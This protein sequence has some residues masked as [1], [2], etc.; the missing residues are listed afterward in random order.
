MIKIRA[1]THYFN[2]FTNKEKQSLLSQFVDQYRDVTQSIIDHLW[3]NEISFNDKIFDV[4]KDLLD[5]PSFISTINL[6]LSSNLY[7]RAIKCA[8]T[9]A[10]SIIKG[11]VEKRKKRLY[12]LEQL[13]QEGKDTA[14]LQEKMDKHP[15]NK[16]KVPDNFKCELN[17]ICCDFLEGENSFDGFIQLKSIGKKYGKIRIPIKFHRQ[18]N[19]WKNKGI[20][21]P[22]FLISK[23]YINMRWEIDFPE[24]RK[25]GLIVGADSGL[26]TCL[27]LSDGQ[28]TKKCPHGH[29]LRSI[30]ETL[31]RRKQGG[32]GFQR[33]QDHRENYVNWSINQLDLDGIKQINLEEIYD[34]NRGKNTSKL[35]KRWKNTLI[36]DKVQKIGEE[37]G[38]QIKLQSSPYRSQRC[39]SCGYVNKSNRTKKVFLCGVCGY[40][41][42]ADLNASLNHL[43]ELPRIGKDLLHLKMSETGFY[44][45]EQGLF[46]LNGEEITVS[47][48]EER[49][50]LHI[51]T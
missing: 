14:K 51:K 11:T 24:K 40:T 4:K 6:N 21:K 3:N 41:D 28:T 42:D 19:K 13:K 50:I 7:E 39:S 18:S 1:S 12:V 9:Q 33:K 47:H 32:N 36:S 43:E 46:S 31:S 48:A 29:D 8:A 5:C 30:T 35:L 27:T 45:I 49:V 15:I 25:E 34:L 23:K 10:C 37:A 22:S 20:L 17:S 44:W 38:V 16:P 26:I 2:N